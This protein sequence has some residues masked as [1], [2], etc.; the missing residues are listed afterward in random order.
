MYKQTRTLA[1]CSSVDQAKCL[2]RY[3]IDQG[4]RAIS[5]TSRST[6]IS[7]NEVIRKLETNEIEDIFTVDLF[8]EGIDI[9]SVDTLLL[10]ARLNRWLFSGNKSVVD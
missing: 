3:F 8:N 5:L 6:G 7:R 4:I 10:Y 1:F 9:P 2:E